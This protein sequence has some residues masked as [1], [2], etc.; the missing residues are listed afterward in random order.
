MNTVIFECN[1]SDSKGQISNSSRSSCLLTRSYT[2]HQDPDLTASC[3]LHS[4]AGILGLGTA[5]LPGNG[6]CP[7]LSVGS[8][9]GAQRIM[10]CRIKT[11]PSSVYWHFSPSAIPSGDGDHSCSLSHKLFTILSWNKGAAELKLSK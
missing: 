7:R 10:W 9:G 6:G 8:R 3:E 4:C 11:F 1:E 5:A 2:G